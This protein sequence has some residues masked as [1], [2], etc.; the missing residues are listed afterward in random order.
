MQS[1]PLAVGLDGEDNHV[2]RPGFDRLLYTMSL[3]KK[4]VSFERVYIGY[5]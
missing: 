1:K 4:D 5:R 3:G 2:Q